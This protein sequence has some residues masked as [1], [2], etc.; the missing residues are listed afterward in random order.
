MRDENPDAPN[1]KFKADPL[2]SL[3]N[4]IQ[5]FSLKWPENKGF[6]GNGE[7]GLAVVVHN[8]VFDLF[9]FEDGNKIAVFD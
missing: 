3:N 7:N 1:G 2:D 9:Y 8:A 5:D 4:P 6:E